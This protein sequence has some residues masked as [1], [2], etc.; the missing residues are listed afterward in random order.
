[1]VGLTQAQADLLYSAIAHLHPGVYAPASHVHDHGTLQGLGDDDHSQYLT[2][3]RADDLYQALGSGGDHGGLSGLGDDDH[4]QYY[5]Q[6]RGDARYLQ[7]PT[8]PSWTAP[9][10][11]NS[12]VNYGT[13]YAPAGYYKDVFGIVHLRGVVKN[14]T[15]AVSIFNLPSGYRPAYESW[16]FVQITGATGFINFK[17]NGDCIASCATNTYFALDG[18]L[19]ETN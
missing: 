8:S 4:T 5:N 13:P 3:D 16:Q 18:L 6:T 17:T 15:N 2:Q 1:M 9:T 11:L 10:L 19:L 7:L 12:W 14:G